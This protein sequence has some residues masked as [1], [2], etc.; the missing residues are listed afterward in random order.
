MVLSLQTF[1][2]KKCKASA[3]WLHQCFICG[4]V[5]R[6]AFVQWVQVA[7][8]EFLLEEVNYKSTSGKTKFGVTYG[9]E[10]PCAR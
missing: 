4:T 8:G 10:T 3:F 9:N 6:S 2:N 1:I 5:L 7:R